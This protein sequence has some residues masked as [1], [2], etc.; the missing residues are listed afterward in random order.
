V[1]WYRKFLE[2]APAD[3]PDRGKVEEMLKASGR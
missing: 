1:K 3:H 2:L